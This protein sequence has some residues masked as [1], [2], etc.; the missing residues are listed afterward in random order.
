MIQFHFS[1]PVIS[2][3]LQYSA[4]T[5][6]PTSETGATTAIPSL[7]FAPTTA[8]SPPGYRKPETWLH[9]RRDGL[10]MDELNDR[11]LR[12]SK[13]RR[14]PP[15]VLEVKI[16]NHIKYYIYT[17]LLAEFGSGANNLSTNYSQHTEYCCT[18]YSQPC[19]WASKCSQFHQQ[20]GCIP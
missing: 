13:V 5:A 12:V 9:S 2:D 14:T 8:Q 16:Y 17:W 20:N 7:P 18:S 4:P 19:A 6:Y 15:W 1:F 3:V 10:T 11:V